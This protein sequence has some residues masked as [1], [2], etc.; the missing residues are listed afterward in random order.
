ML[1][2]FSVNWINY[3]MNPV[4]FFST[5]CAEFHAGR[6]AVVAEAAKDSQVKRLF[7]IFE[8]YPNMRYVDSISR[9]KNKK[10]NSIFFRTEWIRYIWRLWHFSTMRCSCEI[11]QLNLCCQKQEIYQ[12]LFYR[13]CIMT[14]SKMIKVLQMK[15]WPIWLIAL[16]NIVA[17]PIGTKCAGWI[18][19]CQSSGKRLFV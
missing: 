4:W 18:A 6:L 16:T 17:Q 14:S 1:I 9:L 7:R 8:Q 13:K 10:I 11:E 19:G 12:S 3:S 5:E 2:H 15:C